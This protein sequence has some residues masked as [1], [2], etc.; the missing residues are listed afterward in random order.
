MIPPQK[1]AGSQNGSVWSFA[2]RGGE[3]PKHLEK[4]IEKADL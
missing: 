4:G 1:I 3:N 2:Q